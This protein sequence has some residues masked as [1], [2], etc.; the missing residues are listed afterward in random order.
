MPSL[1]V[2]DAIPISRAPSC[3]AAPRTS[4]AGQTSR[5]RPWTPSAQGLQP[6]EVYKVSEV[7]FVLDG[8]HRVS[9]ARQ[10]GW[11]TIQAHVIEIQT[12]IPLTPDVQPDELIVKAE[13]AGF[14]DT[15]RIEQIT[16]N[17]ST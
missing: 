12:D 11:K 13:Y 10:E 8:N 5:R 3:R 16:E 7:Y 1:A 6:I 15:D 9:I 4:S 17:R 2:W 14:L